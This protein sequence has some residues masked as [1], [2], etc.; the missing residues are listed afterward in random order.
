MFNLQRGQIG[1]P[2]GDKSPSHSRCGV[3]LTYNVDKLQKVNLQCEQVVKIEKNVQVGH[4]LILATGP[5]LG[6]PSLT[7][8]SLF[9]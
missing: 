8:L 4:P 1:P 2:G 9:N 3:A 6:Q 7:C 5:Y